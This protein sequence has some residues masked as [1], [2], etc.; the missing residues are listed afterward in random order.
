LIVPSQFS[1][2][3]LSVVQVDVLLLNEL[4]QLVDLLAIQVDAHFMR[5]CDQVGV[6]LHLHLL[7]IILILVLIVVAVACKIVLYV[8]FFIIDA[9]LLVIILVAI[10]HHSL[11]LQLIFAHLVE[12]VLLVVAVSDDAGN[13]LRVV[14]RILFLP[15]IIIVTKLHLLLVY[16]FGSGDCVFQV[17]R[18]FVFRV[19]AV[20]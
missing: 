3:F 11:L 20:V 15:R 2:T 1:L 10:A 9:T 8:V 13:L 16:L 5:S 17:D 12:L 4:L 7:V 18:D 19:V 6:N 14:V